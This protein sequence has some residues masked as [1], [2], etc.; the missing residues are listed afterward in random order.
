MFQ[1]EQLKSW[2]PQASEEK[3][4]KFIQQNSTLLILLE[5]AWDKFDQLYQEAT[6]PT[7]TPEYAADVSIEQLEHFPIT[8]AEMAEFLNIF[9]KEREHNDRPFQR[10]NRRIQEHNWTLADENES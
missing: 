9:E 8:P 5:E 1:P 2:Q 3:L 7:P 6:P 4:A 10:Q